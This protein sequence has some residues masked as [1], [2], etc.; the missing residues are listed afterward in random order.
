MTEKELLIQDLEILDEGIQL[1]HQE[2]VARSDRDWL[3]YRVGNVYADYA[4][5]EKRIKELDDADIH[6]KSQ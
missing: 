4:R 1:I 5:L 3:L 6:D 2:I